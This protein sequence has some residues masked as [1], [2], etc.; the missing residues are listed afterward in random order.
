MLNT[1]GRLQYWTDSEVL[2]KGWMKR[3]THTPCQLEHDGRPV[4]R[5]WRS[6]DGQRGPSSR[7][8]LDEQSP[9]PRGKIAE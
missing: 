5:G 6:F 4:G 7:G 1:R 3:Q 2:F 9:Q 8:L